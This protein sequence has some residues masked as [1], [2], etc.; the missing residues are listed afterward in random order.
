MREV[1]L[2]PQIDVD[3]SVKVSGK[4]ALQFLAW[5]KG[6]L[7]PFLEA[8][9]DEKIKEA[10]HIHPEAVVLVEEIRRFV[11]AGGKRVRPGFAYAAYIAANGRSIDSILY[12]SAALEL[13][14][15]FALIHDDIMD[16]A[17]IRRGKPSAHVAFEQFHQNRKFTGNSR[18]F[19][20]S[21][22]ILAGDM[23][24]GFADEL[25]H[26]SPFPSERIRRANIYFDAVK[27]Q[28]VYGQ[29]LDIT[30]SNKQS[31][32]EEDLMKIIEYKTAKYTVERPLHIGAALAGAE[33]ATFS[34]LSS[35][36]LPMGKAFQ[37]QDDILGTFST[38]E[39][40]G[41][42]VDSDIR[43]GKKTLLVVKAYEFGK[44]HER[45]MMDATIG[46][47]VSS[48]EQIDCVRK[49]IRDSGALEY[50][51]RLANKLIIQAKEA[52][53]EEKLIE[54]GRDHLLQAAD[55]LL[56]RSL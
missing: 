30:A 43:E 54:E 2:F 26:T 33:V 44:P 45:N 42:P 14:Q 40:I 37:I 31:I 48:K 27:K 52:I 51:Q 17:P 4:K 18:D 32:S 3:R 5:F 20:V 35:Y 41:K 1:L 19:G 6:Q 46:N 55:Y 15:A 53:Y 21:A 28:V 47:K 10:S 39:V 8:Y 24:L 13:L 16:K 56:T 12:A 11:A 9:F 29:Y 50:S 25:L 38:E 23:A 7:D 49:I 22:A 34:V 36:G